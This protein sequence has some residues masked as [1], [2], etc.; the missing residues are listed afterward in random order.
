MKLRSYS[1]YPHPNLSEMAFQDDLLL[2][3]TSVEKVNWDIVI[4]LSAYQPLNTSVQR[5]LCHQSWNPR[6]I[7]MRLAGNVTPTSPLQSRNYAGRKGT[8]TRLLVSSLHLSNNTYLLE[9]SA[10]SIFQ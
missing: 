5:L 1:Q 8:R 9:N 7:N 2:G 10:Q 3:K 4:P 6:S